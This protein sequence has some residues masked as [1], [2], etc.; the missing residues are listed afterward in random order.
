MLKKST[1]IRHHV[2]GDAVAH[3]SLVLLVCLLLF[4]FAQPAH[5]AILWSGDVS[6]FSPPTWTS[7]TFATIGKNS[8]GSL[9]I[10][11]G[12]DVLDDRGF[13]GSSS[14]GTGEVT[15]DGA[16]STWTNNSWLHVGSSGN[17]TLDIINGGEVSGGVGSIGHEF[18]STGEVTVDGIGSTWTNTYNLDVGSEGSGTLNITDGGAV[19]VERDT[20]VTSSPGSSGTINF[21]NGTLTTGSLLCVFDDLTGTG[22]INT[23]GLVSD[24]DLVFDA[25]HGLSKTF[26]INDNPGQNITVNLN[27]DGS[28]SMGAGYDGAGSMSISD[29]IVIE[30]TDGYIGQKPGSTGLVTVDGPGSTWTSGLRLFVGRWGNGTLNI[31]DGGQVNN[32]IG[33]I[34]VFSGTTSEATV[35]GTGS[36]WTNTI[37]LDVGTF[38]SGTLNIT[39]GGTVSSASSNLG[40]LDSNSTGIATVNGA[41]STW[42]NSE[43]LIVG[44][45]GDGTLNITDGGAVSNDSIGAIGVQ[46]GA[47]GEVT[48]DGDGSTWTSGTELYVGYESSGTLNITDGGLVS[49]AGDLTIDLDEDGN[50]FIN[51]DTGGMLA[52]FGDADDSLVSYKGLIDGTDAIR[53]W[54]YSISDWADITGATYGRDYTLNY[55]SGGALSGYTLLTVGPGTPGDAN[56]DGVV[57][58]ADAAIVA[59]NWQKSSSGAPGD[60]NLDGIVDSA[61]AA[62]LASNWQT[63]SGATWAEGDFNDDG[64]V[65]DIDA[66]LLAG[67]WQ[68]TLTPLVITWSDGDFNGDGRVNDLDATLL[69]ANWGSGAGQ[70]VPEPWMVVGLLGLWLAGILGWGRRGRS[71]QR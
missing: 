8:Y 43:N 10:T 37:G 17:G 7:S 4:C 27:V 41:G 30:S 45:Q 2:A 68:M 47:T 23:G 36:T 15:V 57:N 60:A 32:S 9:D 18:G 52:L 56:G 59:A 51:M 1:R 3:P 62:V 54:D 69:A 25:T 61:D 53:Y 26:N 71:K 65:N 19:T 39:N 67:N 70:A 63:Q 40:V 5:A 24:V 46:P 42:T 14:G 11:G 16:G 66:T 50:G 48:V 38:G 20:W 34:G 49:V 13:I 44:L 21:D 31:T 12:S 33:W 55:L 28:G 22:T 64:R 29:G 35:D 6:P 58:D